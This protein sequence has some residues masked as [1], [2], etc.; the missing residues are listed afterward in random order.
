MS[1]GGLIPLCVAATLFPGGDGVA[2]TSLPHP[3]GSG[4]IPPSRLS[5]GSLERVE[6]D[7]PLPTNLPE[8]A[9]A[10]SGAEFNDEHGPTAVAKLA[11]ERAESRLARKYARRARYM[12]KHR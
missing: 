8:L 11:R 6:I 2:L 4:P 7:I 9:Y 1:P 10:Y 5:K 3:M 12:R